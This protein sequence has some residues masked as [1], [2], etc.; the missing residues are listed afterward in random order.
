VLNR[1]DPLVGKMSAPAAARTVTF[2]L[3]PEADISAEKIDRLGW[4]GIR[5]D[6]RY[7]EKRLPVFLPFFND[8]FL[9]NFLAAAAALYAAGLGGEAVE[10]GS[11][12][13]EAF[14]KRGNVLCLPKG[15]RI[16]DDSYNSS[17][18]ALELALKALSGLPGG[19]RVVVLGDMLELGETAEEYH[20]AAGKRV[21]E[22]GFDLLIT[23][24]P[25]ARRMAEGARA[26]GMPPGNVLSADDS[27]KAAAIIP[28]LL[29]ADDVILVKGSRGV[30]TD[31]I[32]DEITGR[33]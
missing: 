1:D 13:L 20:R 16:V 18:V 24:G 26:S 7:G 19:R 8:G 32:V 3:D 11:R 33:G 27:E 17:P 5:F 21:A 14:S 6:L 25:L 28:P 2:G 9:Y 10:A 30:R 15:I 4:E 22:L 29:R 31:R 12:L 23:V